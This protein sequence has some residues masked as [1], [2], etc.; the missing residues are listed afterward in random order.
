MTSHHES[1]LWVH[2]EVEEYQRRPQVSYQRDVQVRRPPHDVGDI[3]FEFYL[4]ADGIYDWA[5][6][7]EQRPLRPDTIRPASRRKNKESAKVSR[8]RAGG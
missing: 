2:E 7:I 4:V 1:L 8:R 3:R 6:Q 5:Q